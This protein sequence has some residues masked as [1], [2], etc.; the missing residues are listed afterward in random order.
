[1][2]EVHCESSASTSTL[3]IEEPPPVSALAYAEQAVKPK[4]TKASTTPLVSICKSLIA[5]G[6]AGGV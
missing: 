2:K 6:V 1:M 3:H 5:G 4:E